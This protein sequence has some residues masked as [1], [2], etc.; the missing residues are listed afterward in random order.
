MV[1]GRR[2]KYKILPQ[3]LLQR[4]NQNKISTIVQ[5]S[6]E[7]TDSTEDIEKELVNHF[8]T[9]LTEP[10]Q[11]RTEVI[12]EISRHIP[13]LITPDQNRILMGLASMKEVERI[14]MEM[15]KRKSRAQMDSLLSSSRSV[16]KSLEKTFG[17]LWKNS[18]L[19]AP[20]SKLSMPPF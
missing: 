9:L 6:G 18:E 7:R 8:K 3:L 16:G 4:R 20:C 1:E 5:S 19:Q 11:D 10:D 17:R 13:K 2:S 15:K 12:Q 14:V